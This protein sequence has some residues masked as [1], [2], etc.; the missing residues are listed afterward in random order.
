MYIL[1]TSGEKRLS[2]LLQ[3]SL[4]RVCVWH[5]DYLEFY[6]V[7]LHEFLECLMPGVYLFHCTFN[8]DN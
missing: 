2:A 8:H 1:L 7:K 6:S 3:R 4:K 5:L